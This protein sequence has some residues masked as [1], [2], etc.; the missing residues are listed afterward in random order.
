MVLKL[1]GM[2]TARHTPLSVV[3][4]DKVP[5]SRPTP[6]PDTVAPKAAATERK[7][8]APRRK[9]LRNWL[10]VSA[11]V[12]VAGGA[13]GWWMFGRSEPPAAP[14]TVAVARG[15]VQETVL[16]TGTLE[17]SS[18][19][20]VGAQVSG[21]VK[22]VNVALGDA[23]AA[24]DVVATIDSLDQENAV[25]S[26]EASLANLNAQKL[27]LEAALTQAQKTYDRNVGLTEQSLLAT[28]EL[29]S[30]EAGLASAKAALAALEAQI[31]QAEISVET[32]QLD[33]SRTTVT[34]PIAGTVVAVLVQ[35]GDTVSAQQ[36]APTIIK[37]ANL[38]TML[39]KAEISEADVTQVE[40][41][42]K[43]YF[44]ILGDPNNRIE[45]TLRSV[46]PAP[47]SIAEDDTSSSSSSSAIYYNGI[48]EVP[49]PDH[50][51][52]IS[53]TAEV[54]IVLE[55]ATDALVVPVTALG[56]TLPDGKRMVEVYDA[57][58]GAIKPVPVTV[59]LDDG[60]NAAIEGALEVGDEVI[61]TGSSGRNRDTAAASGASG[62]RP[63]GMMGMGG[64]GPPPG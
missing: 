26:A 44:T 1:A 53:M 55:E 47:S 56:G 4:D 12:L 11:L 29:D 25:R 51:L 15:D 50:V 16:A 59:L 18:L 21:T 23:I 5:D 45:A 32:A 28:S 13:G 48:F 10:I 62:R 41:G 35:Q 17:A 20:S 6:A 24:G 9:R 40:A 49:N 33:L 38:D 8:V 34:A 46:E 57:Q 60:V 54:T 64:M 52:R 30:A 58:S 39:I 36:T 63:G 2:S 61:S 31:D 22:T 14:S 7:P 37:I 3:D 19:V 42:Q 27:S 43:V